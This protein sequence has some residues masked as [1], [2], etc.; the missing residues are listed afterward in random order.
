GRRIL[1]ATPQA[2]EL[3]SIKA[4][5]IATGGLAYPG[6][7]VCWGDCDL[8]LDCSSGPVDCLAYG[9]FTGDNGVFGT[10]AP[11]PPLGMALRGSPDRT[12]QFIGGNLLDNSLGF[13]IAAP[14]PQ[15]FHGDVG[16]AIPTPTC[17]NG[18]VEPGEDCDNGG[19]CVGG[20]NAGT[21]CTAE[22][23]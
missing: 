20:T 9:N 15:N 1:I 17:G 7:R 21:H 23:Q 10:P 12:N 6:G 5:L 16:A 4:D 2:E 14:R 22:S 11:T 18:V 3:F 19:T 13:N 8:R